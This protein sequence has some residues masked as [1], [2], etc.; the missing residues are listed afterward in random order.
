MRL[1]SFLL[2]LLP[3]HGAGLNTLTD[4]ER[5]AGWRLLFDGKTFAGWNDPAASQP[6]GDSWT[7]RD[8]ALV[9]QKNP[10]ILED[11]TTAESF[12]DFEL[13]FDW[14]IQPGGNSGVK[15]R[16]WDSVFLLHEKPGWDHG[17]LG[18]RAALGANERGQTYLVS[19]EFQL[20]D[21]ER[22]PDAKNGADRRAGALYAFREPVAPANAPAGEWHTGRLVVRGSHVEH[23][24]DGT[25]LL[26]GDFQDPETMERIKKRWSRHES[27]WRKFLER[28]GKPSPIA[29][30]N[31]GDSVVEFH[32]LKIRTR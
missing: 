8:G 15:Y 2:L 4:E 10:R 11:L 5:A 18:E 31:H 25:Q 29:L 30:Q 22:H 9:A 23:W 19:L 26:S 17:K 28:A 16:V 13:F 14:R 1:L 12:Q 3:L 21:D 7:I 27:V 24:I 6:A 20:L 32:N